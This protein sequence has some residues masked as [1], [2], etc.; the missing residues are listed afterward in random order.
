MCEATLDAG[1]ETSPVSDQRTTPL[2]LAY[3][4]NQSAVSDILVQKGA[5]EAKTLNLEASNTFIKQSEDT[6]D[7]VHM[8]ETA[9]TL[10]LT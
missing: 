4:N 10:T 7:F 3:R 1:A 8:T 5:K 2:D 6:E 9:E